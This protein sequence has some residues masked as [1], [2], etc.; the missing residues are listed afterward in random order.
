MTIR[1]TESSKKSHEAEAIP[2]PIIG[3]KVPRA[4]GCLEKRYMPVVNGSSGFVAAMLNSAA[5]EMMNPKI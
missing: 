2:A 3:N 1:I 5:I 4:I